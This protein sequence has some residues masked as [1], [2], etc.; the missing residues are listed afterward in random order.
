MKTMS[1]SSRETPS[2]IVYQGRKTRRNGSEQ[3]RR[4]ILEASLRLVIREGVRGVR[5][6]AVAKEADVPLSATTYYFKDIN[7]LIADTFTYFVDVGA[8]SM[9][10]FWNGAEEVLFA[11]LNNEPNSGENLRVIQMRL[12]DLGVQYLMQQIEQHR[13]YLLAE[14]AFQFES[15][16]DGR[17]SQ[18]ARLHQENMLVDLTRFFKAIKTSDP[19]TDA[20]LTLAVIL[21]LE[22]DALLGY[23]ETITQEQIKHK[24]TRHLQLILQ[25]PDKTE[26]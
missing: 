2:T 26:S 8:E 22:Y 23:P 3:R 7:D 9:R 5:H 25:L 4:L 17:L 19:E 20:Y 14:Q 21:R 15:L 16:R 6:R 12:V 11:Q 13:D 1:L 24:L 18:L 10:R